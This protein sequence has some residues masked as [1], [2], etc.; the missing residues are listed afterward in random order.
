MV[1]SGSAGWGSAEVIGALAAGIFLVAAF[2]AWQMRAR[3]PM[4]AISYFRNRAFSAGN[5]AIFLTFASLFGLV[6][7]SAQFLQSSLGYTPLQAGLRLI[8]WTITFLIIAPAAGALADRIGERPLM[9]T[10]LGLQTL[11][12]I[13]IALIPTAEL[14][15]GRLIVPLVIAGIGIS[16]S[17]PAAQNSVVGSLGEDAIGK[18]AG[19]NSMMRELGGVFG[20]ALVATTFAAVGS[21]A[22]PLDVADG[23]RAAAA[24]CGVLALL[25]AVVATLLPARGSRQA[26]PVQPEPQEA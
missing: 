22:S 20:I 26:A 15:Y 17:I 4:L 2:I 16:M 23:F 18:A 3:E 19:T 7:V 11:G 10:G 9:V 21:Y 8:P 12:T 6:F 25:G 24:T 5:A 13:W 1:R 14:N